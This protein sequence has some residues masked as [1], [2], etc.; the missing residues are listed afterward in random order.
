[1]FIEEI[2][3]AVQAAPRNDLP[4]LSATLWKAYAGGA[5][6]RGRRRGYPS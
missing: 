1:M 2:R 6:G 4:R 3:R 5:I